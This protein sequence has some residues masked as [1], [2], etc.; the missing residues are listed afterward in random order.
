MTENPYGRPG[1]QA[2]RT[3]LSWAR[4]ALAALALAALATKTGISRHNVTDVITGAAAT[5]AAA[6]IYL[7]GRNRAARLREDARGVSP[8]AVR[9]T[10]AVVVLAGLAVTTTVMHALGG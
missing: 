9:V 7:C 6:V 2:E 3:Q 4:T 1:A 5:L 8:A 10:A